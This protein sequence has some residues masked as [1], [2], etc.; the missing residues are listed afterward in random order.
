ML[1]VGTDVFANK[2]ITY[3][4]GHISA[5]VC[6]LSHDDYGGELGSSVPFC[7]EPAFC[8]L[9]WYLWGNKNHQF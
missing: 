4:S 2:C 3:H 8:I 1:C 7:I 9:L 5:A 6:L